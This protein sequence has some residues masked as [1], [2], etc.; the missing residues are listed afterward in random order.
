LSY[1]YP[2]SFFFFFLDLF[3]FF[4]LFLDVTR[5]VIVHDIRVGSVSPLETRK[6][7][8]LEQKS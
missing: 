4:A 6:S 1:C 8:L 7:A 5:F 2:N 3:S